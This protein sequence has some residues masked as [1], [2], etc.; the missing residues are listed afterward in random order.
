MIIHNLVRDKVFILLFMEEKM[1]ILEIMKQI[2]RKEER[3]FIEEIHLQLL[4]RMPTEIEYKENFGK[5]RLAI[6]G[7]IIKT[8]EF[9]RGLSR[10]NE[11][12]NHSIILSKL[13]QILSQNKANYI[14]SL[15]TELLGREFDPIG[16]EEHKEFLN[17]CTKQCRY[18]LLRNFFLSS[19]FESLL[20]HQNINL[21]N[22]E[23]IT[24]LVN[25]VEKTK[26]G[27]SI[28]I[29]TW[30]GL[31]Y[32]KKCL[33]RLKNLLKNPRI[34][35]IVLDNG[36]SDGTQ[37]YLKQ[38]TG[39]KAV[40]NK[41]NVGY[42]AGI[43]QAITYCSLDYDVFLL[44]NDMII[45]QV[46]FLDLL[47][48]TAY[49]DPAIGLVG[50]R[51]RNGDGKLLHAGTFIYPE[52]CWGQQIGALETEVNQ[53]NAVQDV[54]G[55]VFAAVYIKRRVFQEIGLLDTD[56][57]AYF[58]D[59]DYCFRAQK[60]GYR[61]VLDGRVTLTH[62][63]NVS[64]KINNVNF[65]KLF[66]TS[67]ST[68]RD[69]WYDDLLSDYKHELNWHSIVNFP[70]G[71]A[72]SS[73]NLMIALD[74][75]KIKVNYQYVYG[76][77]TPFPVNEPDLSNNY[78]VN[79]FKGRTSNPNNVEVVY[80]QGDVFQKNSGRYKVGFTML[81]VDGLPKEWVRQSNLMDEVWVPS[82]FNKE[83][84]IN[85]GV[86]VPIK[87]IPLGIDP[88]YFNPKIVGKRYSEKYTFLSI[89]EWGERKAPIDF[90]QTF[91][92]L[93]G[94]NDDVHLVC[95]IINNDGSIDV[96]N[97]ISKLQIKN[98]SSKITLLYNE[99]I[100]D[101]LMGSLYRSADCFVLPTRGEGWGMPILEAMACGIPTIATN[102]SAQTEFLN[103]RTGY[104]IRVKKLIPAIAKCPYYKGFNWA[105]PDLDH[106]AYLMEYVYHNREEAKMK[107][108]DV[109]G[110]ILV[111]WNWEKSAQKIK[112]ALHFF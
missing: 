31:E 44:N 24:Q 66:N 62:F 10:N 73:K 77:G 105:Q 75:K 34:E 56:Y 48:E 58:E 16:F 95:K 108:I 78:H 84:F 106:L 15:Y 111:N 2:F 67:R 96:M 87:V 52:T 25:P 97:E 8:K 26:K 11:K 23:K 109:A 89:F 51:L 88:N 37:E 60:A 98:Q 91:L 101:Y 80:G 55:V 81:E 59:T 4:N 38:I 3:S 50:C 61:V 28:I 102:W 85:S 110:D 19:E 100:P 49:N 64:T 90:I 36:S 45:E 76:K 43:N 22:D 107:A 32:T 63:E 86:Q 21:G 29:L 92:K 69:K 17:L 41:H 42:T 112:D 70:S 33:E 27:I 99:K 12:N 6:F 7:E 9:E 93:F 1:I 40:F 14:K 57:F 82:Q 72:I 53:Y 18:F 5:N 46:D 103:E 83:T 54:Q 20:P 104:P 68:F 94:N 71:Y 65:N 13:K 39:I 30:N 79:I 35:I 47:Q 74:Q